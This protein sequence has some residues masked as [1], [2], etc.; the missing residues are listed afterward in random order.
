MS[1]RVV[2]TGLG[3]VT[4]L[5]A[6][7]DEVWARLM[8]G[9]PG[10]TAP[11]KL[12]PHA[13]PTKAVGEIQGAL[14]EDLQAREPTLA[15]EG[16]A[17]TL[18][19]VAAAEDALRRADLVGTPAED[20]GIVLGSG[21]GVHRIEDTVRSLDVA[22]RFDA[23]A[24]GQQVEA[25]HGE[26][27][28]RSG[29]ARP[30]QIVAAR[31]G[32]GGPVHAVTTACSAG[33]QALGLGFRMVRS[34]ECP[35]VVAGGADSMINPLGLVFFVLLG[36]SAQVNEDNP[37]AACR[38]FDRRRSGLVMGEGAGCV[39]LESESHARARGATILA[40]VAGYGSSFDAYRTTAPCPDGRGAADAIRAALTDGDVDPACIDFVNAHGTGTKR[41][42]PAEVAAIRAVFGERAAALAVS[43]GK[44][45]MGHL[46]SGAA[47]VAF[48]IA[49]LAIRNGGVPPTLNL[50]TPDPTCD[51]DFVPGQGRDQVVRAAINN[52]FAFG[53]QNAVVAL[54][55]WSAEETA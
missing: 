36:A 20:A 18:F 23:V 47:G 44:A 27:L 34:G 3:L 15:R 33:N 28:I 48:A 25:I 52:S 8:A 7:P 39:V 50:E 32:I 2:V 49:V 46:L 19:A 37:S 11:Q 31:H 29:A 53:G 35:W 12:G 13:P 45:A 38:P 9:D 54:R 6:E 1:E 24:F 41:N 10:V 22:G 17:R 14:L 16:D 30:A 42:D 55:A 40:E 21:P 5:G 26:S 4:P 43:S 51:L